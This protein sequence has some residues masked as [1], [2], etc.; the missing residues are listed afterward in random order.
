MWGRPCQEL[1]G[2]AAED[3]VQPVANSSEEG[4]EGLLNYVIES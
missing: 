2:R 3:P 4:A 1:V